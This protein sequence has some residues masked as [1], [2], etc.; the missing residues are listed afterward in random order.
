MSRSAL[1]R[2]EELWEAEGD[3]DGEASRNR[4]RQKV[5]E[6]GKADMR[7]GGRGGGGSRTTVADEVFYRLR[8]RHDERVPAIR[9]IA[10]S[11][12]LISLD[13]LPRMSKE[14][15]SNNCSECAAGGC[16]SGRLF[17]EGRA[18]R[19]REFVCEREPEA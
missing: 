1:I 15:R 7:N 8:Q 13:C 11:N 2:R 19:E 10:V 14:V 18:G 4:Q 9:G 6:Q 12:I 5:K 3:R 17:G 16:R